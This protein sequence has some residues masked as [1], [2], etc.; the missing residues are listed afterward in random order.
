VSKSKLKRRRNRARAATTVQK[1]V[2]K[3]RFHYSL[4]AIILGVSIIGILWFFQ[5]GHHDAKTPSVAPS[6]APRIELPLA[7]L[8]LDGLSPEEQVALLHVAALE[9]GQGLVAALPLESEAHVLLGNTWRQLGQ[10]FLALSPWH[11]ALKLEPRRADVHTFLAILAEE[12]GHKEQ[13][14]NHW[15]QVLSLQPKR[16]GVRD[17]LAN[18]L[19]SLNQ[20]DRALEVLNEEL[21]YS[22]QSARTHYLLGRASLHSQRFTEAVAHYQQTLTLDPN[23]TRAYYELATALTHS[24]RRQE[25]QRYRSLFRQQSQTPQEMAGG[26][27]TVQDDLLKARQTLATLSI[28][29]ADLVQAKAQ[30][31]LVLALLEQGVTLMPEDLGMRKRLAARYRALG[32]PKEALAQCEQIARLA[33]QDTTCQML[34]GSLSLQLG[35]TARAES[36]FRRMISLAPERSVGYRELARIYLQMGQQV[37]RATS[38]AEQAVSLEPSAE[39]HFLMGQALHRNGDTDAAIKALQRAVQLDPRNQDYQRI[40]QQLRRG[41]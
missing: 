40:Y 21:T 20:W 7:S 32:R 13:A 3:A 17:S 19:M 2:G 34:I 11:K 24:G 41:R 39:N 12:K 37:S 36:A 30:S 38:L 27:F 4:W 23:W 25:A 10:S 18:T 6:V 15:K 33:P 31:S 1:P 28:G 8:K 14:L 22:P 35:R 26:G 29:A 9:L 16:P 5:R